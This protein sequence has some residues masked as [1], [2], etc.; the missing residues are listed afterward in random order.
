VRFVEHGAAG[1]AEPLAFL[2]RPGN[3]RSNTVVDD[4]T[5]IA[6]ALA[7]LPDGHARGK[8]VLVRIDGAG[9]THEGLVWLT[10]R[11]LSYSVGFSLPGDLASIQAK[12]RPRR[13]VTPLPH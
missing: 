2:L 9:G 8:K 1:T 4:K 5:V 10:R 6:V 11:R 3:A 13:Y 7:Q 12:Q